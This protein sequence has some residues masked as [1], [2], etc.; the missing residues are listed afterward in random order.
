MSL[1]EEN[2]KTQAA[3]FA[4]DN[5][6]LSPETP[7]GGSEDLSPEYEGDDYNDPKSP[8][9][10]VIV[11]GVLVLVIIAGLVIGARWLFSGDDDPETVD[12]PQTSQQGEVT[13]AP[14]APPAVSPDEVTPEGE[15]AE[16]LSDTGAMLVILPAVLAAAVVGLSYRT[17]A[18]ALAKR[19]EEDNR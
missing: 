12:D 4:S 3:W 17:L 15:T 19:Q 16:E 18:P 14:V 10:L 11:K 2:F 13:N 5:Q 9:W 8:T 6:D 7:E 1:Q